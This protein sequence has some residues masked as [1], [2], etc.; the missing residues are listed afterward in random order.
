[1]VILLIVGTHGQKKIDGGEHSLPT[2]N[3]LASKMMCA[4]RCT[5]ARGRTYNGFGGFASSIGCPLQD[6]DNRFEFLA[7]FGPTIF[8]EVLQR[9]NPFLECEHDVVRVPTLR[10]LG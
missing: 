1:M 3:T 2:G 5:N 7:G 9:V 4:Q 8:S 6:L 10:E